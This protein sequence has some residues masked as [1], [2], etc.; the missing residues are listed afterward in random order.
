MLMNK[1]MMA[2]TRRETV[3]IPGRVELYSGGQGDVKEGCGRELH[4]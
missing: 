3:V 1:E 4:I 2:A